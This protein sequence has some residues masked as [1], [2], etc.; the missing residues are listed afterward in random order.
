[1]QA[2][3]DDDGVF[4]IRFTKPRAWR[5]I[6]ETWNE[7]PFLVIGVGTAAVTA[8]GKLLDAAGSIRSRNAYARQFNG[9]H[10]KKRQQGE[11]E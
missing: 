1:V 4:T 11:E 5:K 2:E 7:N 6:K 3:R 10:K 8:L 9:K